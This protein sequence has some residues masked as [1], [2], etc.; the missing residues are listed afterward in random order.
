MLCR[1]ALNNE[2]MDKIPDDPNSHLRS[3]MQLD[4]ISDGGEENI[5]LFIHGYSAIN[6]SPEIQKLKTRIL[7][8]QPSGKVYLLC[9]RSGDWRR[10][11]FAPFIKTA[12]RLARLRKL[13]GPVGLATDVGIFA[14]AHIINYKLYER[15]AEQM[16]SVLPDLIA[17]IPGSAHCPIDLIGHSLGARMIHHLLLN[18]KNTPLQIRDVLLLAGAADTSPM[19]WHL[20]LNKIS[21][22][23]FNAYSKYDLVLHATPDM[24]KRVGLTPILP[25]HPRVVNLE[26]PNYLHSDYWKHLKP[27]MRAYRKR[28]TPIQRALK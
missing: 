26:C 17:S 12:Y 5:K 8:A 19:D 4:L 25:D 6:R 10:P 7:A 21:G 23:I 16:G 9:W 2:V 3:K 27:V 28:P 13:T 15:R 22:C 14:G 20:A 1:S 18:L 24:R 11:S